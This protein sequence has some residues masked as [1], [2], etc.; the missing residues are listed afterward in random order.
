MNDSLT[1]AAQQHVRRLVR[2]IAPFAGRL[3]RRFR[4]LLGRGPYTPEQI[5]ALEAIV[6]SAAARFRSPAQFLD[7]VHEQGRRLARMNLPPG[8]TEEV[9]RLYAVLLDRVLGDQLQPPREQLQLATIH[10]LER[11][12]FQVR[13]AEAQALFG[14]YRAEQESSGIEELLRRWVRVLTQAFGAHAGR[15]LLGPAAPELRTPLYVERGG[16]GED[17]IADS[18]WRGRHA[19]YWSFPLVAGQA[20]VQFAF[21][22]PGNWLA[23]DLALVEAAGERC[24]EAMERERLEKEVRQLEAEARNKEEQERRRIGRELHDEAGQSLLLL[25]LELEMIE[26][27]APA[28]LRPRLRQS[29]S[30]AERTIDELRRI[31]AALSPAVLERLGLEAALQQMTGRFGKSHPALVRLRISAL[32]DAIPMPIQEVVYRVAQES[33]QNIVKHSH[34]NRVNL[35]LNVTDKCFRLS[36]RDNGA[37]FSADAA[38]KKPM[39]FGLSGMRERAALL[40]GTLAVDSAPGKGVKVTLQLPRASA[41]VAHN[42]KDTSIDN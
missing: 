1:P 14:F 13:E 26:R 21:R 9:L 11:A 23:R 24:R 17:W 37:G 31:V 10:V 12:Y 30:T 25:R 40:G 29:R 3:E 2:A 8:E 18:G 28:E 33:L 7:S 34:A 20:Y 22:K 19:C 15:L 41:K 36:V 6:P 38:W 16:A 42:G 27:D 32:P 35:W 5:E 39:S 4:K